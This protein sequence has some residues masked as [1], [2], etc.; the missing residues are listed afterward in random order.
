VT[1]V[2]P[3]ASTCYWVEATLNAEA[4]V[5]AKNNYFTIMITTP[6]APAPFNLA[7]NV[8]KSE[9]GQLFVNTG[10]PI[11]I[12]ELSMVASTCPAVVGSIAFNEEAFVDSGGQCNIN[13][14]NY[15]FV[16]PYK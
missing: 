9:L 10:G 12:T 13:D 3:A 16:W 6:G 4:E 5:A 8:G 11:V 15:L 7:A 2:S 14:N 1:V